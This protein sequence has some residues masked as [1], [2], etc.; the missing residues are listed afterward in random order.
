L[1]DQGFSARNFRYISEA[2]KRKGRVKDLAFF[3]EV[4]LKTDILRER[5]RE[6]KDFR[7][8]H[9]GKYSA[10][11]QAIFDDIKERREQARSERDEE[12]LKAL[13]FRV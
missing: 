11:D 5:I 8:S 12:L 10:S 7:S 9:P 2:E 4:K 13:V 1:R 3:P 6:G